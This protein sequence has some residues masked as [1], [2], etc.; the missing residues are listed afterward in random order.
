LTYKIRFQNTGTD[1][2][3]NIVVLDTL[4]D[5]L[6]VSTFVPLVSS[7]PYALE[8]VDSNVLKYS[9]ENIMLPDSNINEP[10][11]HGLF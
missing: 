9:F 7:H 10:G 3:F 6:D 5:L 11:S 2:A 1:T 4:S 8:I